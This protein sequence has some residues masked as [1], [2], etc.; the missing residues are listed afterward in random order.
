MRPG[1][2]CR[3][4]PEAEA[5]PEAEP[6]GPILYNEV[7]DE[8]R[9]RRKHEKTQKAQKAKKA[10]KAKDASRTRGGRRR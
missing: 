5:D 9:K 6:T 7:E 10:K 8:R 3:S 1:S 2:A 4:D